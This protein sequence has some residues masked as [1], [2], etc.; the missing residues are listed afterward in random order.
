[1]YQ[2]APISKRVEYVRNLYRTTKPEIDL[3]RYKLV[4]E[5]YQDHPQQCG[6]LK[7]AGN[8]KNLFEKMPT[9]IRDYELIVGFAGE[10]FRSS[11][12]FP[13]NSHC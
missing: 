13:E 6:I 9:P 3:N 1:M 12:L 5:Y 10:K 4:T 8:L 2:N 11:P 7:R